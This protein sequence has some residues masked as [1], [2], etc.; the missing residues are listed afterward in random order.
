MLP[1]GIIVALATGRAGA[2]VG[3]QPGSSS[4][5]RYLDP[6]T[7]QA[8]FAAQSSDPEALV[9]LGAPERGYPPLGAAP[10]TYVLQ[11]WGLFGVSGGVLPSPRIERIGA[12]VLG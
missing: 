7:W 6:E 11:D 3:R 12:Q 1:R 9:P 10:G 5:D 2:A 8:W 4:E